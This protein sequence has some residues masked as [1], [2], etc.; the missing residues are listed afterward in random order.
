MCEAL[1]WVDVPPM[2]EG[3]KGLSQAAN[4]GDLNDCT[5][6]ESSKLFITAAETG[7][8]STV[9]THH[10]LSFLVSY[11]LC[12]PLTWLHLSSHPTFMLANRMVHS[13]AG[14]NRCSGDNSTH[15]AV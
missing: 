6:G 10:S 14:E 2:A 4:Q 5:G 15:T 11:C 1:K 3:G 12:D 8:L 9:R 13:E 7:Y